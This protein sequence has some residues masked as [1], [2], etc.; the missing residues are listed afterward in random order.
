MI[1]ISK[2]LT[3]LESIKTALVPIATPGPHGA[4]TPEVHQLLQRARK[5]FYE[6][7]SA[8]DAAPDEQAIK[9]VALLQIKTV[10]SAIKQIA[11]PKR[12]LPAPPPAK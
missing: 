6:V 4:H 3:E 10:M 8:I 5:L 12:S 11:P 7:S 2:Y 9:D 1:D